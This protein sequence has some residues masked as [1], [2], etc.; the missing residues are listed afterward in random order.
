ML[1][2]FEGLML[3]HD[4]QTVAKMLFKLANWHALAK[5]RLHT[6]LTVD[7]FRM[8][9]GHMTASMRHFAATMCEEWETHKLPKEV[10]ARVHREEKQHKETN[11]KRKV[12]YFNVLNT[13]K[14]HSLPDYPDSIEATGTLDNGN[15]QVVRPSINPSLL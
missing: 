9:T 3:V 6:E 2:V 12:T 8:A 13:Y 15:T 1:P 10:D 11:C 4:D 7:I 14:F 5:L